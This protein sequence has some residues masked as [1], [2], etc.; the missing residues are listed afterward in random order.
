MQAGQPIK[1]QIMHADPVVRAGLH[2]ILLSS[3]GDSNL[4]VEHSDFL[5]DGTIVL[6]D[7][8]SG[9]AMSRCAPGGVRVLIVAQSVKEWEV[10]TALDSGV[11]GYVPQMRVPEVLAEAMTALSRGQRY[12]T[13]CV[14]SIVGNGLA[15]AGL[16]GRESE[17]LQLL[18]KGYCNKL[19]ARELEIGVGTV[20]CH[21]KKVLSKLNAKA[22]THAVVV[23]SQRGLLRS[24]NSLH[25][26]YGG[27]WP[28]A[29]RLG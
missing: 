21:V 29:C 23:A 9:I 3:A 12:L 4:V 2:T 14:S 19:I 15:S 11:L 22:R 6:S 13:G 5:V 10:R 25:S 24:G 8:D 16:T 20:K 7:Y 18:G 28:P 27:A 17:V 26:D 1:I